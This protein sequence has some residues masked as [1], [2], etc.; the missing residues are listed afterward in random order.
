MDIKS[1][2]FTAWIV[3]L[4]AVTLLAGCDAGGGP[5][6][7]ATTAPKASPQ[8]QAVA[9]DPA[10][11]ESV[12][13]Q[14]GFDVG[15]TVHITSAGIQPLQLVSL[16]CD[17]VVFKN[18]SGAAVSVFFDVYKNVKSGPIAPGATWQWVPPNPLS[19]T[20]H[21]GSDIKQ[22]GQIQVESANW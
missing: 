5:I 17:P 11:K 10:I 4:S 18:E 9:P 15:H 3:G 20:Y 16:C 8:P 14:P 22:R 12:S 1:R 2:A 13:A 7:E 19:T 6:A 21:L